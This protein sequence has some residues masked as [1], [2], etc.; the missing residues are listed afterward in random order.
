[1]S[2][3]T[4]ANLTAYKLVAGSYV[5]R[6]TVKD[7]DGATAYDDIKITVN[8]TANAAPVANAG[9]DFSL[10]LPSSTA[11]IYGKGSDSDGTIASYSWVKLSGPSCSMSGATTANLTAYKLV[12][13]SYVFRL[14]VKDNDGATDYDDIKII[15]NQ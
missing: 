1:M 10:T 8:G 6:L 3:A 11:Y 7:N 12:A 5:F 4:T 9:A 13:G 14:T 15:V 2:G